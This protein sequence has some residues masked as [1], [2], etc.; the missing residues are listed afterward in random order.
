MGDGSRAGCC[1]VGLAITK[2]KGR[3]HTQASGT[4]VLVVGKVA[5]I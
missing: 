5:V 3:Y 4:K 2:G 1:M